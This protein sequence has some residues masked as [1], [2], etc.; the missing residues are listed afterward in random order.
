MAAQDQQG[1]EQ[2]T[3]WLRGRVEER[4]YV[5][6]GRKSAPGRGQAALAKDSGVEQSVLSR[7]LSGRAMP[8]PQT[9][10]GLARALSVDPIDMLHRGG[11]DELIQD[12]TTVV[13]AHDALAGSVVQRDRVLGLIGSSGLPER[14]RL[15]LAAQYRRRL[16]QIEQDF[17]GLVAALREDEAA[18]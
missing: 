16:A 13:Q 11:H 9:L 18:G 2:F 10:L 14:V 15:E 6:D 4:G 5:I 8:S 17:S 1:R 7:V 12:L 3:A